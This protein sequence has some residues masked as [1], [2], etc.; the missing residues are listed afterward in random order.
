M[1]SL[2]L[3]GLSP[4]GRIHARAN[5]TLSSTLCYNILQAERERER[6]YTRNIYTSLISKIDKLCVSWSLNASFYFFDYD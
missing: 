6:E 3:S 4:A 2:H 5:I 1:T